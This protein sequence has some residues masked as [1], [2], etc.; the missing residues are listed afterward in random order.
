[1]SYYHRHQLPDETAQGKQVTNP[2][3][4]DMNNRNG[5]ANNLTST[6]RPHTSVS[7]LVRISHH[8]LQIT[9]DGETTV[10]K[11]NSNVLSTAVHLKISLYKIINMDHKPMNTSQ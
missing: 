10:E 4:P 7:T 1:M 6:V 2:N 11:H 9:P 8:L 5:H 3:K